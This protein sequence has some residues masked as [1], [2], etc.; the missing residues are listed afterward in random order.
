[1][2]KS[3][4]PVTIQFFLA[5]NFAVRTKNKKAIKLALFT[6]Q[7]TDFNGFNEGIGLKVTNGHCSI[8][9]GRQDPR[10]GGMEI[11]SL[12]SFRATS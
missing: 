11:D 6:G 9:Q 1:M 5:I 8:V 10:L 4:D 3:S 7:V 2:I 12:D